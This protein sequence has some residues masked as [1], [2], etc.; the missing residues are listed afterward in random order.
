MRPHRPFWLQT[1][2]S[3]FRLCGRL[4]PKAFRDRF[5][6]ESADTFDR[7]VEDALQQRGS[8]AAM[9]TAAAACGD[10]ARAGI[11]ARTSGWRG[12]RP[13]TGVGADVSHS[14]RIFRREP[15]LGSSLTLILALLAGPT[16]AVF[17]VLYG[18]GTRASAL[19]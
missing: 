19:P 7:L 13:V 6:P 11:T 12:G 2:S 1:A 17:S 8:K 18:I 4:T 16:A 10:I 5:G 9:A 15:L 14:I 3:I